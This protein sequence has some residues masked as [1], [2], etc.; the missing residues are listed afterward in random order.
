MKTQEWMD[1]FTAACCYLSDIFETHSDA[2]AKKKI[3]KKQNT[4]FVLNVIDAAIRRRE[5]LADVGPRKMN[6]F[7]SSKGVV[8]LKEK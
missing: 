8:S 2:F 6:L 1:G 4:A 7:I 5:T 3:L